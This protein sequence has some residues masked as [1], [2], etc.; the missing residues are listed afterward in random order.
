MGVFLGNLVI[1][2]WEKNSTPI[3][4]R[5]LRTVRTVEI[6]APAMVTGTIKV[7]SANDLE[8]KY[9]R[10]MQSPAGTDIVVSAGN[11]TIISI[12]PPHGIR[13]RSDA[14]KGEFMA[15]TFP[16]FGEENLHQ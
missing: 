1:P 10:D 8:N 3:F 12:V 14:F 7:Q 6:H 2:A 15:R 11:V 4:G 5:M 9:Y 16:V 13:V